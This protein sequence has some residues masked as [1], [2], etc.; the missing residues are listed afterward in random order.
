MNNK[1][2]L[3]VIYAVPKNIIY[4]VLDNK[5]NIFVKY[6]T[7]PITKKSRIKLHSGIKLYLYESHAKRCLVG[8]ADIINLT[9]LNLDEVI[10][11]YRK[12]LMFSE[13][14]FIKYSRG[15]EEKKVIVFELKNIKR[16]RKSI[17]I[18]LPITMSGL[19]VDSK[20]NKKIKSSLRN[21]KK[22]L[23]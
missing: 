1:C 14:E 17:Q 10:S 18:N 4:N 12:K 22:I 8:E 19:Y 7:H 16:Y 9:F 20:L 6:L 2:I 11:L 15:R 21:G 3:G 13:N 23:L 5:K